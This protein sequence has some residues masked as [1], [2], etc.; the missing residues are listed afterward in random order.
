M[1]LDIK[2]AAY[3]RLSQQMVTL[4]IKSVPNITPFV[5]VSILPT[6]LSRWT[7]ASNLSWSD[8]IT[9]FAAAN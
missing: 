9:V 1:P 3:F 5:L 4:S 8:L 7:A 2:A 6:D